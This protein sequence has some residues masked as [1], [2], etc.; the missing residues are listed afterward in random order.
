MNICD[1]QRQWLSK[2]KAAAFSFVWATGSRTG[3]D[4][5][6]SVVYSDTKKEIVRHR[7]LK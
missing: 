3:R 2:E 4:L 7:A 1:L 5:W 6:S